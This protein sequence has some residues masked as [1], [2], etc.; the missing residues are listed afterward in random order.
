MDNKTLIIV[1]VVVFVLFFGFPIAMKA[2]NKSAAPAAKAAA[3]PAPAARP[4]MP[5]P[6]QQPVMP[7]P[8]AYAPQEQPMAAMPA[9][10]GLNAQTL[11]GTMWEAHLPQGT[12]KVQINGGGQAIASHPLV[13]QIPATWSVQGNMVMANA[14]AFGQNISIAAEIRGNNLFMNG[15]A[16]KRLH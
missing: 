6:M 12:V 14:S 4:A 9:Q 11:V 3:A 10:Q 5:A 2:M 8:Q 13:G 15:V 7:A 1:A 16:L